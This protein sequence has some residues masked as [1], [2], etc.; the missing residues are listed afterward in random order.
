M[1]Q[2]AISTEEGARILLT[3]TSIRNTSGT[4]P[5]GFGPPSCVISNDARAQEGKA[6]SGLRW[7]LKPLR[8][9]CYNPLR[10]IDGGLRA[11][12]FRDRGLPE[13]AEAE[14]ARFA[15]NGVSVANSPGL[16]RGEA[17]LTHGSL[18]IRC[19][20]RSGS[21]TLPQGVGVTPTPASLTRSYLPKGSGR[22]SLRS[23]SCCP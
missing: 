1:R 8:N 21:P 17:S 12:A 11:P 16:G 15:R 13:A 19:A 10:G 20:N 3:T 18:G 9:H 5:A 23:A 2:P 6:R 4:P 7:R 14:P 22:A